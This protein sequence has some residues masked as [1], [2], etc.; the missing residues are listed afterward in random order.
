LRSEIEKC[1][2]TELS[3]LN[4]ALQLPQDHQSLQD[5]ERFAADLA[6]ISQGLKRYNQLV[7]KTTSFLQVKRRA[8][9]AVQGPPNAL[10]PNE[11]IGLL[12]R[13]LVCFLEDRKLI[14]CPYQGSEWGVTRFVQCHLK[15][16][17]V[18]A[19]VPGTEDDFVRRLVCSLHVILDNLCHVTAAEQWEELMHLVY[20]AML[21]W[22]SSALLLIQPGLFMKFISHLSWLFIPR[23]ASEMRRQIGRLPH[24][25][26]FMPPHRESSDPFRALQVLK[27]SLTAL[28]QRN[29]DSPVCHV[30]NI[31]IQVALGALEW[32]GV[33]SVFD[34]EIRRQ[35][36]IATAKGHK[37]SQR[38]RQEAAQQDEEAEAACRDQHSAAMASENAPPNDFMLQ[39]QA[40]VRE[41]CF[42]SV[43]TEPCPRV[44]S[45][46]VVVKTAK[47]QLEP[48][49]TVHEWLLQLW[50][51]A[52]ASV[53]PSA[54]ASPPQ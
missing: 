37:L 42:A 53:E 15:E 16:N 12:N 2:E 46:I 52:A 36:A 39:F 20:H 6:A 44:L 41:P 3:A 31:E 43:G 26:C 5:Y 11:L 1:I 25:Q 50:R 7:H 9:E 24:S 40:A 27:G 34:A 47:M 22:P 19:Q 48:P 38:L 51:E 14:T 33:Q 32:T 18:Y 49:F 54:V 8:A 45:D 17:A 21:E 29:S 10:Q 13:M 28:A 30:L 35:Q 23:D 4:V